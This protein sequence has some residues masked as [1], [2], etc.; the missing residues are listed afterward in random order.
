M[1]LFPANRLRRANSSTRDAAARILGSSSSIRRPCLLFV[2]WL[3][4]SCEED[5]LPPEVR[6]ASPTLDIPPWA[7]PP[8][9]PSAVVASP[10][11]AEGA[12]GDAEPGG[13]PPEQPLWKRVKRVR[14]IDRFELAPPAVEGKP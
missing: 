5:H 8:Q 13:R 11:T 3:R 10:T 12:F 2:F 9:L 14:S 7:V 1:T 4:S 6:V